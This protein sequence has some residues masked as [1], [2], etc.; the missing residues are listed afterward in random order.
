MDL[1]PMQ[2]GVEI[3]LVTSCYKTGDKPRCTNRLERRLRL[4]TFSCLHK[5]KSILTCFIG[6]CN[7]TNV[8]VRDELKVIADGQMSAST[9]DGVN[10]AK[11]GRLHGTMAWCPNSSDSSPRLDIDLGQ[12]YDICAVEVQGLSGDMDQTNFTV[13]FSTDGSSFVSPQVTSYS[14]IFA[15]FFQPPSHPL[16]TL[17]F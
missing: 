13:S 15:S 6:A 2:G 17:S 14:R 5:F 1:H 8:G 3:L 12:N 4:T 11:F 7:D 9:D 16:I 10:L